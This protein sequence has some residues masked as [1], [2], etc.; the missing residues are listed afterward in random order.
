MD[1][2][3]ARRSRPARKRYAAPRPTRSHCLRATSSASI[4][5]RGRTPLSR[6]SRACINAASRRLE[7]DAGTTLFAIVV[8]RA[9]IDVIRC[10]L[11]NPPSVPS[12]ARKS[13]LRASR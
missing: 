5:G 11:V 6:A 9:R 3:R 1:V 12:T 4:T 13:Y 10:T 2:G 7:A 8:S